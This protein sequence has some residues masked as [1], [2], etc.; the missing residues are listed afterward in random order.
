[1]I[2]LDDEALEQV[3]GGLTAIVALN[4]PMGPTYVEAPTASIPGVLNAFTQVI[5]KGPGDLSNID[6][7][8]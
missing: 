2:R 6:I 3:V 8:L 7:V 5:T 1:M 4:S